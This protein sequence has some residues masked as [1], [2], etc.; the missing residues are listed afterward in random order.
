M[1][2][3]SLF[4]ETEKSVLKSMYNR[5]IDV[6]KENGEFT[7]AI[8]DESGLMQF[9]I[10]TT[11]QELSIAFAE[12]LYEKLSK[13]YVEKTVSKQ[14]LT[15]DLVKSK[16]DSIAALLSQKEVE[17]ALFKDKNRGLITRKDQLQRIRIAKR[18]NYVNFDVRRINQKS[19][20][21]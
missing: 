4:N 17:L 11:S 16:T 14:Q 19:G 9:E 20:N 10:E 21:S 12:A 3:W 1:I 7:S 13:Y 15:Y 8:S 5:I 18:S 2:V 6:Q